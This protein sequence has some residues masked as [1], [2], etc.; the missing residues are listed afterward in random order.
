MQVTSQLKSYGLLS[1]NVLRIVA[2]LK[3]KVKKMGPE[4]LALFTMIFTS[5]EMR[6]AVTVDNLQ[7]L[8]KRLLDKSD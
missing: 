1:N 7:F 4:E 6:T 5:P 8:E 2:D 3:P